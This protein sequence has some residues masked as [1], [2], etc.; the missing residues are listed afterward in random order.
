M[1]KLL[2]YSLNSKGLPNG[3][4]FNRTAMLGKLSMFNHGGPH[5]PTPPVAEERKLDPVVFVDGGQIM[6]PGDGWQYQQTEDE[7]LTKK[8]GATDWIVASGA[9]KAAIEKKIFGK[10]DTQAPPPE[11]Q[12]KVTEP[13]NQNEVVQL[14]QKL[15]NAGYNLGKHI[16]LLK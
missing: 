8:E 12:I 6:T 7:I 16:G 1:D 14:L 9:P 5:D 3:P 15:V 2:F 11:Q 4:N 10:V 13:N